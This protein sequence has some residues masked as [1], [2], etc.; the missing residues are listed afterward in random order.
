LNSDRILVLDKG[1]VAEF[2]TPT[3]LKNDEKSIFFQLL[4]K[5]K[6]H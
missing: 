1:I 4:T 3:N 6:N 2:D 5:S